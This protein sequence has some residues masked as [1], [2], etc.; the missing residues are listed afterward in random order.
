ML[1]HFQD[2]TSVVRKV[3]KFYGK[4]YTED[5]LKKLENYL[6]FSNM[7]NI[8]SLNFEGFVDKLRDDQKCSTAQSEFI[9]KGEAGGYRNEMSEETVKKFDDWSREMKKKLNLTYD[10]S[11][12]Y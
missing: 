10:D 4:N 9:R 3:A 5:E 12:P 8:K 11:I 7:K 1:K 6:C 2:Y